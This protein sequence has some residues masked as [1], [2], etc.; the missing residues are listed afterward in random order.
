MLKNSNLIKIG[1]VIEWHYLCKTSPYRD[2]TF[3]ALMQP[4]NHFVTSEHM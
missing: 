3:I 1:M 2:F 4:I